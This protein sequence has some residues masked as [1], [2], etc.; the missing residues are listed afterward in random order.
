MI[1]ALRGAVYE[2][3][4]REEET[5]SMYER[6]AKEAKDKALQDFFT[7]M[8]NDV[9]D[10]IHTLKNLNLHSIVKFGLAIKFH[11]RTCSIDEQSISTV[12]DKAGAGEI[13]KLAIDEINAD[14]EYYEHIAEHSLFPEVKRLFRIISDK[15]L[16]HKCKL[17]A[18]Q[19]LLM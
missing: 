2:A 17:K 1:A 18:L 7:A 6:F 3:L 11:V 19:D 16:E 10:D 5:L 9:K 14:I 13:L 15:E 4:K 12:Q 8:A